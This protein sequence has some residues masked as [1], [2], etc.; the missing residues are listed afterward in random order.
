MPTE[1]DPARDKYVL[2]IGHGRSGTNLALDLL[3]CHPAT[4]CRNEPNEIPGAAMSSLAGELV[5]AESGDRFLGNWREAVAAAAGR[6]GSRDRFHRAYKQYYS[7]KLHSL[8]AEKVLGRRTVR[9][10]LGIKG[11]EWPVPGLNGGRIPV[12]KILL[13][14][15]WTTE[16]HAHDARQYVIHVVRDPVG[17]VLSWWNRYILHDAECAPEDVY[18]DNLESVREI[19]AGYGARLA[20]GSGYSVEA[21]IE[22]ELWR[23]RYMNEWPLKHLSGSDRY[24]IWNYSDLKANTSRLALAAFGWIGIEPDPGTRHR[25]SMSRNTLFPASHRA[26]LDRELISR[27]ARHVLV[28]SEPALQALGN[29]R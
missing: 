28:G 21:L 2:I 3:D 18:N 8:L 26:V 6:H 23:W 11:G 5:R 1:F 27:L 25:I 7:T 13:R 14:P 9:R 29:A 16:T 22:T 12:F 19:L 10:S 17:F 24:L 4:L 20:S 15:H